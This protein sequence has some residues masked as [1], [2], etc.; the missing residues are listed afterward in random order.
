MNLVRRE[1]QREKVMGEFQGS[2][3]SGRCLEA[4]G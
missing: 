2:R 1:K 3:D 4:G